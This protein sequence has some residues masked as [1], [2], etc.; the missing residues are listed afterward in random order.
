MVPEVPA[1]WF[2]DQMPVVS[3]PERNWNTVQAHFGRLHL[4]HWEPFEGSTAFFGSHK[5]M[6]GPRL[7]RGGRSRVVACQ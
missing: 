4:R 1:T 3:V 6:C 2:Q 7:P 5:L